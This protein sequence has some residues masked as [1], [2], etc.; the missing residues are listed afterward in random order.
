MWGLLRNV[1]EPRPGGSD[2]RSAASS[3]VV[4]SLPAGR[5][6]VYRICLRT[7][8]SPGAVPVRLIYAGSDGVWRAE[9]EDKNANL[10]GSLIPVLD[11][12]SER[13]A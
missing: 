4:V 12:V 1:A 10:C 11:R 6:S 9:A 3:R 7:F 8:H 13:A 2:T 5:G